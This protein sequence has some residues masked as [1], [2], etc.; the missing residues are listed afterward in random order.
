MIVNIKE[1][2][3]PEKQSK[4][5]SKESLTTDRSNSD[6]LCFPAI[7]PALR[8]VDLSDQSI[9]LRLRYRVKTLYQTSERD[10]DLNLDS[11]SYDEFAFANCYPN[12]IIM[13]SLIR[14][15]IENEDPTIENLL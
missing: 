15:N 6:Y 12:I 2:I 4:I 8:R 11:T 3:K 13:K 7:P 9:S 10:T 1:R 14:K 5:F